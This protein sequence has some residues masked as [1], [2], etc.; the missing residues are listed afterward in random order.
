MHDSYREQF[1]AAFS[2]V[3]FKTRQSPESFDLSFLNS[4]VVDRGVLTIF[5]TFLFFLLG[6]G[7]WCVACRV[8]GIRASH[9]GLGRCTIMHTKGVGWGTH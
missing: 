1:G 5:Q 2:V 6:G 9:T 8:C 3:E 4:L 7:I